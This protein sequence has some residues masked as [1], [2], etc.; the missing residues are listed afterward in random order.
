MILHDEF[1]RRQTFAT[2]INENMYQDALV[3]FETEST[4]NGL[5]ASAQD[6]YL[7]LIQTVADIDI[8]NSGRATHDLYDLSRTLQETELIPAMLLTCYGHEFFEKTNTDLYLLDDA[9]QAATI[10]PAL[11]VFPKKKSAAL[12]QVS[13]SA[14]NMLSVYDKIELSSGKIFNQVPPAVQ[15]V[16]LARGIHKRT[17]MIDTASTCAPTEENASLMELHTLDMYSHGLNAQPQ[18]DSELENM[19]RDLQKDML[20]TVQNIRQQILNPP[21]R[22][23]NLTIV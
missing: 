4:Q 19:F 17:I 12:R 16:Y 22:P 1:Q 23:P 11:D 14:Q 6:A 3:A 8:E 20:K 15:A 13:Q 2:L 18:G 21:P 7:F 9:I 5:P 10:K